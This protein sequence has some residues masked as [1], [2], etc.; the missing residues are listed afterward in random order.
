MSAPQ[1][2]P[3]PGAQRIVFNGRFLSQVQTGVQRYARETLLA[4]DA[5]L[6][7]RADLRAR[8]SCF[9]ALPAG[10]VSPPLR[11]IAAL[12]PGPL[13][14]H[15]WEQ[16]TL[17]WLARDA[18]LVN[19]NYSGPVL[20]R[21]QLVTLH[22]ATVA[23]SP[24]TFSARYR[25][26]HRALIAL[27]RHRAQLMMTVS[28]FS[29]SEVARHFDIRRPILVGREGWE[30]AV[31]RGDDRATL[32]KYGLVPG[33]YVLAVGSMKPNK[34]FGL[35]GQAL[36]KMGRYR[37]PIAVAGARDTRVF[38]SAA[39]PGDLVKLLGFVSDGELG[40]LYRH[41]AW[42]VLPSLYEGFGLPAVEAMGNGC[43]VI[44]AAAAS[45]PEVCGDAAL[46]FDP[47]DVDSLI[48]AL[49]RAESEPQLRATLIARAQARLDRYSWHAN[50]ELI[51]SAL[52]QPAGPAWDGQASAA[53][54]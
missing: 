42:F 17:P 20:T 39:V 12:P 54:A 19:F 34:N 51:A 15:A 13:R 44:A 5:L 25:W 4:F 21:R 23:V 22:D 49:R 28:D 31:A 30:H 6:V 16:L 40:H 37:W 43:P 27:L 32:D 46:Y 48:A 29:R 26:V 33:G 47:H 35:L 8:L 38:Q 24:E 10:T 9:I 3:V 1:A 2:G 41:A 14:G 36:Q 52:V 11:H 50:A 7:R 18:F 45:I 53:R